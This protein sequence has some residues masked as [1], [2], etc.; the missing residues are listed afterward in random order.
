MFIDNKGKLFGKVSII[1][2][3]IIVVVLAVAAGVVY[4]FKQSKVAGFVPQQDIEIQ[5]YQEDTPD[6]ATNDIRKGDTVKDPARN[7]VF[8]VVKDVTVGNSISWAADSRGIQTASSREGYKSILV[9]VEGKGIYSDNGVTFSGSDYFVGKTL[10]IRAGNS[11][12]WVRVKSIKK[13][14]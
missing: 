4:K 9:T 7:A 11:A 8:G 3:L 2:I 10:E 12:L 13:K 6:F 5:F 14:E 1:D